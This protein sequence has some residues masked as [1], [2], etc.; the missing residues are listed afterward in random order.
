[1][2][3]ARIPAEHPGI[4]SI[5]AT[6]ALSPH[7]SNI[8]ILWVKVW[9]VF[10][11]YDVEGATK[12]WFWQPVVNTGLN[13]QWLEGFSGGKESLGE[14]GGLVPGVDSGRGPQGRQAGRWKMIRFNIRPWPRG[15]PRL[16]LFPSSVNP[17]PSHTL[18]LASASIS[19]FV[20]AAR[21]NSQSWCRTVTQNASVCLSLFFDF[22][23]TYFYNPAPS[24]LLLWGFQ[25]R[26]IL[27]GSTFSAPSDI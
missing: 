13:A 27:N 17:P 21:A 6:C 15:H 26:V 16:N 24:R 12:H 2:S 8:L 18:L 5:S 11:T 10:N 25:F 20:C 4:C 23:W 7:G 22:T 1:M 9:P 19:S 14:R 3:S